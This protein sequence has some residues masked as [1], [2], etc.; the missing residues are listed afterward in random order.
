MTNTGWERKLPERRSMNALTLVFAAMCLFA[1][2]YRVYGVFIANKV[3]ELNS[4]RN[5]PSVT[6]ADGVDYVET[7][8]YVLFGHHF[9]AIAAAGPLLGPVL[10]A[11]FGYLP[12]ALWIIVGAVLAGAVHDM[13]VLFASV[14]HN[15]QS[16]AKIAET[17]VGK[18]IG[19]VASIAIMFILVLTLAGLS[20]AVVNAMFSSPWGTFVVFA[21]MPIAFLMGLYLHVWREGDV[22]GASIIGVV[23]LIGAVLVGPYVVA[24]PTLSSI[25]TLSKT[26]ISLI[27]PVYGFVASVL[28]VW[29]LLC[30]RD[31]LS[32]YLKLGTIAMLALGIVVRAAAAADGA[33][34]PVHPRRRPDHPRQAVPVPVHHHRLRGHLR[35]PRHHRLRHHA[36]DDR[37]RA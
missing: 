14:R 37:Q 16:L 23:L 30:P 5:T 36:Q 9:A 12:G 28:P 3:L 22:L 27:I 35:V 33:G 11:Q 24:N 15:G 8:K 19:W 34:H 1:I 17:E 25:F 21:T 13:V 4:R 7:N 2:G 18:T 26:Q 31:Y 6:V 32:T 10:A 20:I 29:M